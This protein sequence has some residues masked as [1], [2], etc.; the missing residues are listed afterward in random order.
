MGLGAFS[1]P[2]FFIAIPWLGLYNDDW[3]HFASALTHWQW[4]FTCPGTWSRPLEGAVWLAARC[5]FGTYVPGYYLLFFLIQALSAGILFLVLVGVLPGKWDLAFATSVLFVA[6]PTDQSRFWLSTFAY[7]LGTLFLVLSAY[8]AGRSHAERPK[9]FSSLSVLCYA[10][11]ILSNE[12]FLP[13]LVVPVLVRWY[14]QE[15]RWKPLI[16]AG[17]PYFAVALLYG[18]LRLSAPKLLGVL[19][20]KAQFLRP[21]PGEMLFNLLRAVKVNVVAWAYSLRRLKDLT[22]R[23]WLMVSLTTVATLAAWGLWATLG[24]RYSP[25]QN[26]LKPRTPFSPPSGDFVLLGLGVLVTLLGYLPILPTAYHIVIG[27]IDSRVSIAS[28]L[29]ASLAV[30][31][32]GRALARLLGRKARRRW[33]ANILFL[34]WIASL[35]FLAAAQQYAVRQD[36]A[37]AW[38]KQCEI[39]RDMFAK[40]PNLGNNAYVIIAGVPH[41]EGSARV[42]ASP[43]GVSSALRL[44][45]DNESL[46]GDVLPSDEL[47]I[48]GQ[49]S[50]PLQIRFSQDSFAPRH[51][52]ERIPYERLVLLQW[53]PSHKVEVVYSVPDW[54]PSA[55]TELR[56]HP[57]MI[58][59]APVSPTIRSVVRSPFDLW[60]LGRG[61]RAG[62]GG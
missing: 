7:R 2:V 33:V 13:L 27:N 49:E 60:L 26:A 15:R 10:L 36:Y 11:A 34:V 40:V 8:L 42:L 23:G 31:S 51:S 16:G 56:T 53:A 5:L 17:I 9:L 54:A 37:R 1:L 3:A 35:V 46:R 52:T 55:F 24:R 18:V 48:T 25:G 57:E 28:G 38:H 6:F 45:Y 44:L 4:F 19:D 22:M 61:W 14:G 12:V 30:T 62:W 41:W 29:G 58:L 20:A 32:L 47:P 21:H 43:W 59:R 50:E 39:W